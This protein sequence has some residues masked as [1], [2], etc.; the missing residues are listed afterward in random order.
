MGIC[1]IA[2][3]LIRS[4]GSGVAEF[5]R[6]IKKW[7]RAVNVDALCSR[8]NSS[9]VKRCRASARAERLLIKY[10]VVR[11]LARRFARTDLYMLANRLNLEWLCSRDMAQDFQARIPGPFPEQEAGLR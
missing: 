9:Q 11:Q 4:P 6:L 10:K 1:Q 7:P 2:A 3:H 5:F 8:V